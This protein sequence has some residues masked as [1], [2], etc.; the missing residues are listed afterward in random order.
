MVQ[1]LNISNGDTVNQKLAAKDNRIEKLLAAGAG[2]EAILE[3]LYLAALCRLPTP[4]ER[5]QLLGTLKEVDAAD[6]RLVIEDLYWGVLSSKEFLFN[7]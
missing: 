7:H 5:T 1:V 6:H 4:E 2:D 3:D